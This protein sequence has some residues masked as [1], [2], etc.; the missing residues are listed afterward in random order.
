[1]KKIGIYVLMATALL[2]M[3]CTA[4]WRHP[5]K[6]RM[7]I[8]RSNDYKRYLSPSARGDSSLVRLGMHTTEVMKQRLCIRERR[9]LVDPSGSLDGCEAEY[10]GI[11]YLLA[12]D[13]GGRLCH[14]SSRSRELFLEGGARPGSTLAGIVGAYGEHRLIRMR[15]YG[16]M[17]LVRGGEVFGFEWDGTETIRDGERASWVELTHI[18]RSQ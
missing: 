13:K 4:G 10:R 1:M 17:V 6:Q 18:P 14:I 12:F 16:R 15:G 3:S 2:A 11:N 7:G 5:D 9:V 8:C